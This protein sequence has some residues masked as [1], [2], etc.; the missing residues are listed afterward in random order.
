MPH[1]K[2]PRI[3]VG[4][5]PPSLEAQDLAERLLDA[6]SLE[7]DGETRADVAAAI[8]YVTMR[9][10][11]GCGEDDREAYAAFSVAA[12]YFSACAAHGTA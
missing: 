10:L 7:L 5:D 9:V 4:S 8:L 6:V 3:T 12:Q 1:A 2:L 11:A